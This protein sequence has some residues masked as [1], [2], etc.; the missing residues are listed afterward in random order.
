MLG[1]AFPLITHAMFTKMTYAGASS[2][3]GGF[4]SCELVLKVYPGLRYRV[5]F[6]R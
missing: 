5:P 6:L 3:L 1:G 4:V 2:F